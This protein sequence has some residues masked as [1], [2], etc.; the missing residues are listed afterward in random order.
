[1]FA[2]QR[3]EKKMV[4][5]AVGKDEEID[6]SDDETDRLM[7]V[8]KKV[9]KTASRVDQTMLSIQELFGIEEDLE[10]EQEEYSEEIQSIRSIKTKREAKARAKEQKSLLS[11]SE[12]AQGPWSEDEK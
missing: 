1:M 8:L 9:G 6:S 3:E 5:A 7:Q 12:F 11:K 4:D 10:P 2:K